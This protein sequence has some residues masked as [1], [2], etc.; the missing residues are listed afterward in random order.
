MTHSEA[1][2]AP[3][4]LAAGAPPQPC[5]TAGEGIADLSPVDLV[6]EYLGVADAMARRLWRPGHHRD[7]LRQV[8]RLG[9][10]HAALHYRAEIGERFVP[11]AVATISGELKHYLRDQSWAVRPP[12]G[13]QELRL[14]INSARPALTQSLGHNPTAAELGDALGVP[15]GRIREALLADA[16]FVHDA[17]EQFDTSEGEEDPRALPI[18]F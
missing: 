15:A 5:G 6:L 9:L 13:L 12:R 14:K 2:E 18:T 11:Y 3:A 7:D 16:S 1:S 17:L 8:A 4:A 10:V